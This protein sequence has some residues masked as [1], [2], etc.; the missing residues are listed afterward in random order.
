MSG[1]LIQLGAIKII[2]C[3]LQNLPLSLRQA[4]SLT[5]FILCLCAPLTFAQ[6]TTSTLTGE[7]RDTN[8]ATIAG[9]QVTARHIETGLARTTVS[10]DDGRFV[11][12]G[13]PLGAY[14]LTVERS[15]FQR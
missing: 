2:M 12:P 8:G 4:I 3:P 7:I 10:T 5:F 1:P 11:F 6:T 15:G 13:L 9:A 14:E